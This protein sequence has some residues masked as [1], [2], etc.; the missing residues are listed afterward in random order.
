[1]AL[2]PAARCLLG[3]S[4]I[5]GLGTALGSLPARADD[6]P[7]RSVSAQRALDDLLLD[8]VREGRATD[9]AEALGAGADLHVRLTRSVRVRRFLSRKYK[10]VDRSFVAWDVALSRA[11]DRAP[12]G[13]RTLV[14][15]LN[16]SPDLDV[17]RL[18]GV[19]GR[20]V[21]ER[22]AEM[23]ALLIAGGAGPVHARDTLNTV[24]ESMSES[25]L[26][27]FVDVFGGAIGMNQLLCDAAEG[28]A[29][30]LAKAALDHGAALDTACS[31]GSPLHLAASRGT[32]VATLLLDAGA[33]PHVLA[34][35]GSTPLH[36]AVHVASLDDTVVRRLLQA[37]VDP[38]VVNS[39]GQTA[40][41]LARPQH[42]ALLAEVPE[43]PRIRAARLSAWIVKAPGTEDV[44]TWLEVESL[45]YLRL[46]DAHDALGTER[47]VALFS[48]PDHDR[49][50]QALR[51]PRGDVLP[52]LAPDCLVSPWTTPHTATR[53]LGE[54]QVDVR[55]GPVLEATFASGASAGFLRPGALGPRRLRWVRLP[56]SCDVLDGAL[57]GLP[58]DAA[59][60]ALGR[61][62]V[63]RPGV[64][65]WTWRS[66]ADGSLQ[67]LSHDPEVHAP[68][69]LHG[70]NATLTVYV[71]GGVIEGS[72]VDWRRW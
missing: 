58:A 50:A 59:I 35:D 27:S 3:I 29:L 10:S 45:G 20:A 47:F 31:L 72:G 52:G 36:G 21:Q 6:P 40:W 69:Q 38:A 46:K 53:M 56:E 24:S 60:V 28:D 8:A 1:M 41:H 62:E 16:A 65:G 39:K 70:R 15:I 71:H 7:A 49:I 63:V 18:N 66:G 34:P 32:R 23:A 54:R 14:A 42:A 11:F 25:E 67:N 12:G 55:N 57:I 37:G 43:T 13:M 19:L 68:Q 2:E 5:L 4:L 64:M 61:P 44:G 9:A 30:R 26:A 17:R 51:R 22:D 33:D 48:H